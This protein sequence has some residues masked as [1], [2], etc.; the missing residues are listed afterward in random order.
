MKKLTLAEK[1]NNITQTYTETF[2]FHLAKLLREA[3]VPQ[4][5]N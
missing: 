4:K 3:T 5:K 2:S 1:G